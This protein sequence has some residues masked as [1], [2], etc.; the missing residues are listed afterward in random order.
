VL[1]D[2]DLLT[3]ARE[4]LPVVSLIV[5]AA[6]R[7]LPCNIVDMTEPQFDDVVGCKITSLRVSVTFPAFRQ[8][9]ISSISAVWS[10]TGG[11]HYTAASLYQQRVAD[12]YH[13][14]GVNITSGAFGPFKDTGMAA[15]FSEDMRSLGLVALEPEETVP[16]FAAAASRGRSSFVY[17]DILPETLISVNSLKGR[18][19]VFDGIAAQ[20]DGARPSPSS[21]APGDVSSHA[22]GTDGGKETMPEPGHKALWSE[23]DVRACVMQAIGEHL[24][25]TEAG[26]GDGANIDLVDVDSLTAVELSA[27]LSRTL[28][29]NLPATILFDYPSIQSLV[30]HLVHVLAMSDDPRSAPEQIAVTASAEGT[31]ASKIIAMLHNRMPR[32]DED[33]AVST[34]PL[35]RWM[36]AY[37]DSLPVPFGSWLEDVDM[38]DSMAFGISP[39]E[40][41]VMDPQHRALLEI[42][43]ESTSGSPVGRGGDRHIG[44]YVGIQHAE[45]VSLYN[46]YVGEINAFAATS[47]AFS[48]AAGRISYIFGLQGPAMSLDTAC[49]SAFSAL[50]V[51]RED[52]VNCRTRRTICCSVNMML[53]EK[54]TRSTTTSG[55]LSREGRCKA[56]DAA[57]DGYVRGEA[58][59]CLVMEI[60]GGQEHYDECSCAT[61]SYRGIKCQP[62]WQD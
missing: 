61:H 18:M 10:Q 44:V 57:A 50:H 27:S 22:A 13:A 21:I 16:S 37:V 24:G 36:P 60:D 30:E 52:L 62:R 19:A 2:I 4:N 5:H 15:R 29:H 3:W 41:I 31:E 14:K 12:A 55:M 49:S 47:S 8:W 33:D 43:S 7:M 28:D 26:D 1:R 17:A 46:T 45:Y 54:T 9:I 40:A 23:S 51:A 42:V 25:I 53:S 38:F 59:A 6:G 58:V 39:N 48:V 35:Q 34:T 11:A 56:L 32:A 20:R